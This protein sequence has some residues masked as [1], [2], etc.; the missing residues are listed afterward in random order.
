MP[1]AGC[2]ALGPGSLLIASETLVTALNSF[3][4][5]ESRMLRMTCQPD[6]ARVGHRQVGKRPK[7]PRPPPMAEWTPA[8]G[9]CA[10]KLFDPADFKDLRGLMAD[11]NE[12]KR[13]WDQ[14]TRDG[15][16]EEAGRIPAQEQEEAYT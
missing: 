15:I 4:Q 5:V 13:D 9:V 6:L 14:Q 16:L 2:S 10:S 12:L 7:P 1:R 8:P 3:L 11:L